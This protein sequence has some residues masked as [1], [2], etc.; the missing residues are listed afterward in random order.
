MFGVWPLR[1]AP[2]RRGRRGEASAARPPHWET[3]QKPPARLRRD[4]R[5]TCAAPVPFPR[6]KHDA[7]LSH[8][9]PLCN[10]KIPNFSF[11]LDLPGGGGSRPERA[12]AGGR[13][14]LL[15]LC[16]ADAA[17]CHPLP[18]AP[19]AAWTRCR[20]PPFSPGTHLPVSPFPEHRNRRQILPR[21]RLQS[22]CS[23]MAVSPPPKRDKLQGKT[24]PN[25]EGGAFTKKMHFKHFQCDST[26]F[27]AAVTKEL[28]HR[29]IGVKPPQNDPKQSHA[30][31]PSPASRD[32]RPSR[33]AWRR[34]PS[35]R[36][37]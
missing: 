34:G 19:N 11:Q 24:R 35:R 15:G 5:G 4:A 10:C 28:K 25:G 18:R 16:R 14:P 20:Q 22:T 2:L 26:R 8:S 7:L 13:S 30:R 3:W 37:C 33:D 31:F 36:H 6:E 17:P 12:S 21:S 1:A 29:E 27:G 32:F 23:E 9:R